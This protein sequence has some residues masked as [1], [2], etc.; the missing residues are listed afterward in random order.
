MSRYFK[1][2]L[3][4]SFSDISRAHV[5]GA[6]MIIVCG[7]KYVCPPASKTCDDLRS[8]FD[9]SFQTKC[10]STPSE[11]WAKLTQSIWKLLSIGFNRQA[12]QAKLPLVSWGSVR[13]LSYSFWITGITI[14]AIS[15]WN[16]AKCRLQCSREG[17][18]LNTASLKNLL[19]CTEAH[20]AGEGTERRD[21]IV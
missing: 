15:I 20:A 14:D 16:Q 13:G 18:L 6:Y 19:F 5:H 1:I 10:A 17:S 2:R 8:P 7:L 9:G 4:L 21:R 12:L 3:F 11:S